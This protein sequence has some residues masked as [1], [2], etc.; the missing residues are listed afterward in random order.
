MTRATLEDGA[1][2]APIDALPSENISITEE[3]KDWAPASDPAV[4]AGRFPWAALLVMA[5]MG[6]LLIATETMPAGLL[7]QIASGLAVT[8]GTAG[9]FVSAYALGTVVAA[10]PAIALTRGLRRKP[11]F[12]VGILGFL[13]ANLITAFSTDIALSLGARLLA[14][15][16][17]GLLWG[18]TAGY[19]RRITAPHQAG[20]ALSVASVGT[21]VGLAVGTPFGSWLGTTFDWRWSFGVLAVLTV[22]TLLLAVFLVPDAPGQRPGSRA[23][24]ARVFA[25]PGVAVV[26]GVIVSWM[27][28]HNIMYTYIG[29]YLRG[30]S[31]DLPVD[32]ALMT[33]GAAAI[34][35]IAITGAVIDKGLRRLVLLSLGSFLVAG[36]IFIVGHASLA[37]VLAAIVLWGIAFGGAAAQLQTAISAASGENADVANSML[38]V[39][40]N[41]A[42]FAAGVAGAVVISSLDGMVLPAALV[43]LAAVALVISVAGRRTAFPR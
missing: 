36:A 37:A 27:L 10:M 3:T 29:S 23:S 30:A 25:I 21:P 11:V 13:A 19:A 20:R 39:A 31:L 6:F 38:G 24:L 26:L 15:A 7:P 35:G 2:E 22:A 43:G 8:E 41:L 34:A 1:R 33:F 9:Q 28:G 16:F 12:V 4:P 32:I 42:I 17:S 5:L 14:G 40:F 18:M